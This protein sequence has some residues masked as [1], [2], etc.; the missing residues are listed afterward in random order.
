MT[1]YFELDTPPANLLSRVCANLDVML[2]AAK[3]GWKANDNTKRDPNH[4]LKTAD[5]AANAFRILGGHLKNPQ[6]TRPV[7]M[8]VVNLV[9][10]FSVHIVLSLTALRKDAVMSATKLL[11]E[12][13]YEGELNTVKAK[14]ACAAHPGPNRWCYASGEKGTYTIGLEHI[15]LWARKIVSISFLHLL[16]LA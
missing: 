8:E 15:T 13:A 16:F 4:H 2:D 14:L 7:Y 10:H 9:S 11:N 1:I 6:R 12:T 3:L 5:D